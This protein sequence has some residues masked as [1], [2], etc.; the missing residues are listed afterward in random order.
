MIKRLGR[1]FGLLLAAALC[2]Y[3]Y[4]GERA[5]GRARNAA[6]GEGTAAGETGGRFPWLND[7]LYH[8]RANALFKSGVGRLGEVEE[9]DADFRLAYRNYVR[10][11]DLHPFSPTAHF[12]FGQLLQYL[13]ALDFPAAERYFDEYRKAAALSGVDTLINFE[14][15]KILLARWP[16]L[17]PGE[18]RF[19]EDI[20]RSLLSAG[21]PG[22]EERLDLI[23]SLWEINVRDTAVLEEILPPESDVL[24]RAAGFLGGKGIFPAARLGFLAEAEHLDFRRA[25]REAQAGLIASHAPRPDE[26]IQHYRAAR[27][28]LEGIR[29]Y[30]RL[31]PKTEPVP[32]EEYGKLAKAVHL[33]ILKSRLAAGAD[34]RAV[35]DDFRKALD[36]E[37]GVGAAAELES[38]FKSREMVEDRS[39]SGLL[40]IERLGVSMELAFKQNRFRE[41]VQTGQ[42]LRQNLLVVPDERRPWIGRMYELAGDACQRLDDLYESNAYYEKAL[43]WGAEAAVVRIKLRRNYE[44]LNMARDIIDLQKQIEAG[45]T[46]RE[47]WLGDSIWMAGEAFS[48]D[49]VLDEKIYRLELEFSDAAAGPSILLSIVIN[50]K[51]LFEDFISSSVIDLEFPAA[52]GRNT[53]NITPLNRFCRPIKMILIPAE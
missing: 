39:R 4:L 29:F 49:L 5:A 18:R 9:R 20:T 26:S 14:V 52:L 10:S 53:L 25:V 36:A 30:Q 17:S 47:T 37:D 41:V 50:G 38:L 46:P 7:G 13:N 28:L 6:L 42:T 11:L 33:G 2:L 40:D 35:H 45:L 43:E 8:A 21:G 24:R 44:R 23:L 34:L 51:I 48:K 15:G 3:V 12:D 22:R 19:V 32:A 1:G 27:T 16:S 31:S